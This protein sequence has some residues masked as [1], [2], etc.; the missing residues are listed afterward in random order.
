MRSDRLPHRD[1][2]RTTRNA[3]LVPLKFLVGGVAPVQ[4]R[5]QTGA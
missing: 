5:V 2:F 3:R 1:E 4:A